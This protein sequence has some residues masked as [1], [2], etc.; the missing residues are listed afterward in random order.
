MEPRRREG[1]SSHDSTP[2][3]PFAHIHLNHIESP[4]SNI[5]YILQTSVPNYIAIHPAQ[6]F[7]KEFAEHRGRQ[8]RAEPYVSSLLPAKDSVSTEFVHP[9][10][11]RN[12]LLDG[13]KIRIF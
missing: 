9:R 10:G 7:S 2:I 6:V 8:E 11:P 13:G 12:R 3:F 4:L 5:L 1:W